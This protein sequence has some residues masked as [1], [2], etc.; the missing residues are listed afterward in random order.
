M[1]ESCYE[2]ISLRSYNLRAY[3]DN[4]NCVIA[5]SCQF[6]TIFVSSTVLTADNIIVTS[7]AV[8]LELAHPPIKLNRLV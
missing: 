8:S 7:A 2:I 6:Y 4:Y 5:Q 3:H 1:L